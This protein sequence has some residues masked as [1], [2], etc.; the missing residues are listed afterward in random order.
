VDLIVTPTERKTIRAPELKKLAQT[1][2]GPRVPDLGNISRS[3]DAE[4]GGGHG[5]VRMGRL[6]ATTLAS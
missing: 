2:A 3:T 1:M 6:G 5:H 4:A